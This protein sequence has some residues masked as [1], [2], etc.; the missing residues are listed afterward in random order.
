M[1]QTNSTTAAGGKK[2]LRLCRVWVSVCVLRAWV[3]LLLCLCMFLCSTIPIYLCTLVHNKW[4]LH[5]SRHNNKAACYGDASWHS[6]YLFDENLKNFDKVLSTLCIE[7]NHAIIINVVVFWIIQV[8]NIKTR[9]HYMKLSFVAF[10]S[11]WW[12]QRFT[13]LCFYDMIKS[14]ETE[15]LFDSLFLA[16]NASYIGISANIDI[17]LSLC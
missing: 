14:V 13:K 1:I 15:S 4:E 17:I 7:D 8:Y 9:Q 3:L 12:F 10:L 5:I 16:D 2:L 6:D 11:L